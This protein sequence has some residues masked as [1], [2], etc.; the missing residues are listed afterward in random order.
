MCP[1]CLCIQGPENFVD[2]LNIVKEANR[3]S[4]RQ[5]KIEFLERIDWLADG[6]RALFND[7]LGTKIEL[8]AVEHFNMRVKLAGN[9]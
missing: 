5:D 4:D 3:R 6:D 1:K 7:A 9:I 8:K 2:E